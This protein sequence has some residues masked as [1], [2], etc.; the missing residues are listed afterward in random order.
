MT[1]GG[2]LRRGS[3]VCTSREGI[4]RSLLRPELDLD[5]VAD[6]VRLAD[7]YDAASATVRPADAA[8]LVA[9]PAYR[10]SHIEV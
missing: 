8:E 9:A 3:P 1:C 7:R 4:D 5:A 2:P 6:G 10:P